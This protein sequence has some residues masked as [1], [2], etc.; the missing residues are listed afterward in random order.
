M[1]ILN[2]DALKRKRIIESTDEDE[3]REANDKRHERVKRYR[4]LC[5]LEEDAEIT[6]DN[7]KE[8]AIHRVARESNR[9]YDRVKNEILGRKWSDYE[10]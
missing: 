2:E 5:N 9:P 7:L 8:W 1:L 10:K 4:S 3:Y 6:E